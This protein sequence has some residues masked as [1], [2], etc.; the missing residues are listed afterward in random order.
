MLAP[1]QLNTI[2]SLSKP[3]EDYNKSTLTTQ[4]MQISIDVI[5][6]AQ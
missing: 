2:G 4:G 6:G 5:G 3:K 1:W